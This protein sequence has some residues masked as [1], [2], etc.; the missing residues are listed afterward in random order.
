VN[1][2]HHYQRAGTADIDGGSKFQ[3]ALSVFVKATN[4]QW[5]GQ[6]KALTS[7]SL[8]FGNVIVHGPS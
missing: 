6:G 8:H 1:V 7:D 5:D 2:R 3:E 4:K